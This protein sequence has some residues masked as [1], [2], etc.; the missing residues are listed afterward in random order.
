LGFSGC[1]LAEDAIAEYIAKQKMRIFVYDYDYNAPDCAYLEKTHEKMFRMVREANPNLPI[2][3]MSMPAPSYLGEQ[4]QL[5]RKEIVKRTYDKAIEAGDKSVYFID[6]FD[7]SKELGAGDDIF[8][9]FGHPNDLG[10][11]CMANRIER[12]L[13]KILENS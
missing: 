13:R 6:G 7:F 1:A 8:V 2:V 10:F 9:D 11:F 3:C 5:E 4:S 12:E